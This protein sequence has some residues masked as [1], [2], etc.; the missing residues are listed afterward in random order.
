MTPLVKR[1]WRLKDSTDELQ[2]EKGNA[3]ISNEITEYR[4]HSK[5]L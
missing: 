2:Q 3:N 5:S 1:T 4:A